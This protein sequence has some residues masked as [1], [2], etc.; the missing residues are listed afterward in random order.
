VERKKDTLLNG[1]G[2]VPLLVFVSERGTIL[3]G[4]HI[5]GHAFRTVLKK[6]GLP[7]I[8][9]HDLRTPL[10]VC[11]SRMGSFSPT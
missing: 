9:I 4:D 5:R 3:D 10:P 7:H 6:A 11:S 1:W 8:C 2:E